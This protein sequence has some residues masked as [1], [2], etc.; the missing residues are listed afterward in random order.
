MS[1][2]T[3]MGY[4]DRLRARGPG[5]EKSRAEMGARGLVYRLTQAEYDELEPVDKVSL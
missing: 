4:Y 5:W 2:V 3:R 1:F